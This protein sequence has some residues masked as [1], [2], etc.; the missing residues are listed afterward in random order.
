MKTPNFDRDDLDRDGIVVISSTE[1]G[2]CGGTD[3]TQDTRAPKEIASED[4]IFFSATS[5]LGGVCVL[6]EANSAPSPYSYVSAFAAP[7][8]D[9]C[10]IFL[11][12]RVGFGVG[13]ESKAEWA[14]VRENVFP[15]LVRLTRECGLAESNGRH[16]TT[17][18]LPENFGGSVDIRYAGGERISFS[19]NQFPVFTPVTGSRIAETLT[20]AMEGERLPLPDLSGL[21]EIDYDEEREDGGFT[22]AAL[23]LLPDGTGVN[24]KSSRYS[25]PTVYQSE[26]PVE[27][28]TVDAIKENIKRTGILAW[29][30]L[31]ESGF[32]LGGDKKLTFVFD[33]GE[34]VTVRSNLLTPGQIGGGFFNIELEMTAKH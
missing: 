15:A 6:P 8:G 28:E 4:M 22:R 16:S 20:R 5:A 21:R 17:H 7:A 3:A 19:N 26:K 23:K 33:G 10:F 24:A 34:S 13:G 29:A 32:K 18:G 9:G 31:P 1:P 11:S 14:L 2:M 12:T 25:D 27:R 30:G